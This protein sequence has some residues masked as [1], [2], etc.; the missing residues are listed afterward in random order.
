MQI[1]ITCKKI[2]CYMCNSVCRWLVVENSTICRSYVK[3]S[4][5]ILQSY[6]KQF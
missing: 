3:Q 4:S 6:V 2:S 1:G 5:T